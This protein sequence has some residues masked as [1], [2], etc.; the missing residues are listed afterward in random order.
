LPRR[1]VS[2]ACHH[3]SPPAIIPDASVYVGMQW[4]IEIHSAE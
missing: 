1:I 4:A 3:A 2:S